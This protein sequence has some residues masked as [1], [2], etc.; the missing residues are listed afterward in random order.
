RRARCSTA[1]YRASSSPAWGNR[2]CSGW[3]AGP[4]DRP[5]RAWCTRPSAPRR[6]VLT[7]PLRPPEPHGHADH[8]GLPGR[9]RRDDPQLR[10][11]GALELLRALR[12]SVGVSDLVCPAEIVVRPRPRT[13]PL[14][15][16]V[17]TVLAVGGSRPAIT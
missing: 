6:S 3:T 16:S 2:P 8:R 15:V 7:S 10:L 17:W 5:A 14:A 4:P 9:A 11:R 12:V 13:L 1:R